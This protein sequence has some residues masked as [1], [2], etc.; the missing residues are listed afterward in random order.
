[1][2]PE[3]GS[4]RSLANEKMTLELC[5]IRN[6]RLTR[7][8]I[9]IRIVKPSAP[10]TD[11]VASWKMAIKGTPVDVFDTA[12]RFPIQNIAATRKA[13]PVIVPIHTDQMIAFGAVFRAS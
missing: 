11:P 7:A 8:M 12:S 6:A 2:R 5:A 10:P 9:V 13:K 4:P 1:M 3:N